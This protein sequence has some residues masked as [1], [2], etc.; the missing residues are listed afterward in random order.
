MTTP[1]RRAIQISGQVQGV[2]FRPFVYRLAVARRLSG[3]V[4][5][6]GAGVTIEIQGP[7][8]RWTTFSAPCVNRRRWPALMRST[9]A[10]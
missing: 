4:R 2:G 3:F 7:P 6:D 1:Q 5:N 9:S 10:N 8:P